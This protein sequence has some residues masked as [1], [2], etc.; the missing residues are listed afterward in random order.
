MIHR[1]ALTALVAGTLLAT[2]AL[3]QSKAAEEADQKEIYNYTLNMDKIQRFGKVM[4]ALQDLEKK[5]PEA[6]DDSNGK[7]LDDIAQKFQK[8]PD[9]IA[10]LSKNGF[11]PREFAVCTMSLIQTGMA[12]GFKKNGTYKEYPPEMLKLISK[13]NLDFAEQHWDE[14]Q[15]VTGSGNSDKGD[16]Q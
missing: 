8:Y 1:K 9:A 4:A 5:H 13:A 3:A 2:G 15:K 16:K 6:K 10:V 11:T 14:I 12:V 7:T